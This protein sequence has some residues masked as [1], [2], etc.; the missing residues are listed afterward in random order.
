[1]GKRASAFLS[2]TEKTNQR[3][4]HVALRSAARTRQQGLKVWAVWQQC[5]AVRSTTSR[6]CASLAAWTPAWTPAWTSS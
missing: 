1:M 6:V 5:G 2:T 3:P 4:L